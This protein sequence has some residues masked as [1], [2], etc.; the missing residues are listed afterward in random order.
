[1]QSIWV[2][3]LHLPFSKIDTMRQ[4]D[5]VRASRYQSVIDPMMAKVALLSDPF[6][7]IKIN[8]VIGASF[9]TSLTAG[10]AVIIHDHH[11]IGALGNCLFGAGVG[12]GR[13]I[14]VSASIDTEN[15]MEFSIDHH[16]PVF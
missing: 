2:G 6:L 15:K 1:M 11:A 14:T 5:V 10:A 3:T 7:R 16:G 12:T 8:G 9:N 4:T 13:I